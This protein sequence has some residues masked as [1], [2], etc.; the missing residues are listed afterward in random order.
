[1]P[2]HATLRVSVGL[3]PWWCSVGRQVRDERGQSLLSLCAEHNHVEVRRKGRG[4]CGSAASANGWLGA[5]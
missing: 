3:K 1:M 5:S 2:F 4:A